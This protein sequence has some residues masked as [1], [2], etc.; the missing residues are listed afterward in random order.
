MSHPR[1]SVIWYL[2][3]HV[4]RQPQGQNSLSSAVMQKP[5]GR[6]FA[7][8]SGSYVGHRGRYRCSQG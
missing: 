1:H 8:T 2:D 6:A 4:T 5:F 7:Y 3:D